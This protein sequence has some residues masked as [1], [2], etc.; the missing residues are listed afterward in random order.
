MHD[1][2][3][4]ELELIRALCLSKPSLAVHHIVTLTYITLKEIRGIIIAGALFF[5]R[6]LLPHRMIICARS[7]IQESGD[8]SP[9]YL[10]TPC[11]DYELLKSRSILTALCSS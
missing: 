11:D 2:T 10:I 7:R 3:N 5:P 8:F 9:C 1:R 6:F 4:G